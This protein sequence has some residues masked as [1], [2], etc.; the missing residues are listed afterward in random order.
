[1]ESTDEFIAKLRQLV[2]EHAEAGRRAIDAV[3]VNLRKLEAL[4][5]TLSGSPLSTVPN[6]ATSHENNGLAASEQILQTNVEKVV[7]TIKK[8]AKTVEDIAKETG[9]SEAQ[10]RGVLYSKPIQPRVTATKIPKKKTTYLYDF[11]ERVGLGAN[12]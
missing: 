3:A 11:D 7:G 9:L 8:T 4:T 2:D 12:P 6:Q 1:M 10:V 5:S